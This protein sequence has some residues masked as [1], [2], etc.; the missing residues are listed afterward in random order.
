MS[1]QDFMGVRNFSDVQK[2]LLGLKKNLIY[3][4]N[5][6][7]KVNNEIN[8][9]LTSLIINLK[10]ILGDQSEVSL[11]FYSVV[12]TK[13]NKPYIDWSSPLDNIG[14]IYYDQSTG[15]VYQY[16]NDNWLEN[17]DNSLVQAMALTN[18]QLKKDDHERKVFFNTPITPY[19]SGDWWIQENG[20]LYICQL[21]KVS[22]LTYEEND[23]VPSNQYTTTI[24]IKD[25]NRTTV[26]E[27]TVTEIS[28]NYVSVTDLAT[29]GSTT[30]AGENITTGIIKSSNY[31]A[32]SS[33]TLINLNTGAIDTKNFKV[34]SN[35]VLKIDKLYTSQGT[36]SV[37][38][39]YSLGNLY[40][41]SFLGYSKLGFNLS[42]D[43]NGNANG[44]EKDIS[45][46]NVIIPK[47]FTIEKIYLYLVHTPVTWN[48]TEEGTSTSTTQVGY[49]RQ[50]SLY[51]NVPT[52][53]YGVD[54][55][56]KVYSNS[57][58]SL[59]SEISNWN[60]NTSSITKQTFSIPKSYFEEGTNEFQLQS[61]YNMSTAYISR[62]G[63]MYSGGVCG[64]I[65]IYGFYNY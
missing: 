22:T 11:W 56:T 23:W 15:K 33:G 54:G 48:F 5:T 53:F 17:K 9:I 61:D 20:T 62:N 38:N 24:A 65:S 12:P 37:L 46:F 59:V 1:K 34:A 18:S 4:S 51:K 58:N 52:S 44:W 6:L 16:L 14:D 26:L 45:L 57:T 43:N 10:D 19:D 42:Y 50:L 7:L 27:G 35:G 32:D 13:S 41:D 29:G 60:P 28:D 25:G 64:I 55:S 30:I 8:N 39:F 40:G 21:G 31:I 49:A 63:Y 36:L 47:D 3:S 2:E